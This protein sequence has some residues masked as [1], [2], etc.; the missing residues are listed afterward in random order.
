MVKSP[1]DIRPSPNVD[2]NPPVGDTLPKD[3]RKLPLWVKLVIGSNIVMVHLIVI[4]VGIDAVPFS[5]TDTALAAYIVLGLAV[6]I[7]LANYPIRTALGAIFGTK[8]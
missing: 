3:D 6:P 8:S 2:S 7:G 1:K 5:L 4:L